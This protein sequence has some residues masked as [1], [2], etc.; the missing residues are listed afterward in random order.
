MIFFCLNGD[1]GGWGDFMAG[2]GVGLG[3]L[4]GFWWVFGAEEGGLGRRGSFWGWVEGR[5]VRLW[6]GGEQNRF[7]Y[8]FF[9][10]TLLPAEFSWQ[11]ADWMAVGFEKGFGVLE[12]L[13]VFFQL[14]QSAFVV[15][16]F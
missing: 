16:V 9:V 3:V 6:P 15:F 1:W 10:L 14:S 13:F 12:V 11:G 7:I 5:G 4:V 8:Y 2:V